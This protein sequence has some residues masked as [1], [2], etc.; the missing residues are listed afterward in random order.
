MSLVEDARRLPRE[1]KLAGGAAI[2]L[3]VT[4]LLPWYTETHFDKGKFVHDSL[5][6]FQVFTWVEAAV[7]LVAAAVLFLL[8][9]RSQKRGAA[10]IAGVCR[11]SHPDNGTWCWKAMRRGSGCSCREIA[12]C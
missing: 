11:K 2:A 4:M 5:N 6:A 8:Y 3:F 1:Q 9:S 10:S 12:C 7:L